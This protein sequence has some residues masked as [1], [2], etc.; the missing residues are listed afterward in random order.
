MMKRIAITAI[1]VLA[2]MVL[3]VPATYALTLSIGDGI[4]D[5]VLIVDDGEFD[6]NTLEGV[7]T[8]IGPVGNWWLN[9]TTGAT[10]PAIGSLSV[11]EMDISSLNASSGGSA[12]LYVKFSEVGFGLT[13]PGSF[14]ATAGG[15]LNG[16]PG[17]SLTYNT[18]LDPGNALF[19]ET[20]P[21]TNQVFAPGAFSGSDS[22]AVG[23]I[24][25]YSL[26]QVATI[27]HSGAGITSFDAKLEQV[28]VPEPSTLLLLGSGLIGMGLL[29]RR[30]KG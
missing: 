17:S 11:P 14:V 22:A 8:Y 29:R 20:T 5:P 12:T 23:Q 16:S 25:G 24:G 10:Y 19:A 26:T 4:A 2:L 30:V 18:F 15:T 21:L 9:V 7:I 3:T 28:P 6:S 27:F 13:A 1:M